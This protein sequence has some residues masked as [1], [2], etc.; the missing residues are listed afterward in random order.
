MRSPEG[1]IRFEALHTARMLDP[2][3]H[4]DTARALAAWREV[5]ARLR[6]LGRDADR[7][8]GFGFGNVSARVGPM[9]DVPRGRRRF[10]VTGSQT[11][12]R[13]DVTL[14]DFCLVERWDTAANRVWSEGMVP[15]SSESLTHGALYDVGADVRVVLHGHAP[16]I[17]RHARALGLP[18]SRPEIENGTPAMAAEV[19]RMWRE[20]TL[21][22]VGLLV[23]G[24]HEDGVL[25]F[26]R[27][28]DEAGGV[29]VRQ[30]AR[31]CVLERGGG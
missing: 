26:G 31:A 30:L 1:V 15:P 20:S 2:R 14:D 8:Q 12:G 29:L 7:Y 9:G 10:L 28:P 25:A 18:V 16:E 23:M 13:I 11:G 19:V 4:G 21:A 24:G 6:V 17:W 3:V 27:A 22:S 5:L